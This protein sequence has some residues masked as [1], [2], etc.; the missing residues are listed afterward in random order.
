L[1][2]GANP[3]VFDSSGILPLD[4]A[5]RLNQLD[6]VLLLLNY[7]AKAEQDMFDFTSNAYICSQ[8]EK[9]LSIAR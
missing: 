5:L 6:I 9:N 3:N 1:Q 2:C 4:L 8:L 7:K